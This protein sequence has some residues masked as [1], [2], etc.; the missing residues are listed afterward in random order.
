MNDEMVKMIKQ[1]DSE[2]H[3]ANEGSTPAE[4]TMASAKRVLQDPKIMNVMRR[5]AKD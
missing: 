4:K 3:A 1:W 5:L 2:V